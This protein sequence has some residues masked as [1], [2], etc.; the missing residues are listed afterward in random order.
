MTWGSDA[1]GEIANLAT[2]VGGALAVQ[3]GLLMRARKDAARR[4]AT[5]DASVDITRLGNEDRANERLFRSIND[6]LELCEKRYED[7]ERTRSEL[8]RQLAGLRGTVVTLRAA[9]AILRVT[10]EGAGVK[11]PALPIIDGAGDGG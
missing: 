5:S 9:V 8:E 11:V 3:F 7:A 6:R 1:S 10:L 2:G 4:L